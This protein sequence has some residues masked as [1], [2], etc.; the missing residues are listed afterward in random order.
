MNIRLRKT[1]EDDLTIL[2]INQTDNEANYLAAFTP[3]DPTDK[4]AYMTKWKKLLKDN[5]IHMQTIVFEN[6][7]IGSVVKYVMFGEAEITYQI[8]KDFWGK[9]ITTKAV[10]LFLKQEHTRPLFGRVAF[11][12]Y[13]S[14]KVLEKTGFVKIGTDKGFANARNKEIEEYI[15]QLS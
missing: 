13:G 7:V 1:I 4:E 9:G 11:D 5:D 15:Y 14:Q 8:S 3:K 6:E 10:N 2:F 12:N